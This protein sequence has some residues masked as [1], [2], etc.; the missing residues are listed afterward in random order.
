M[1]FH[2]IS[3]SM[4]L[5]SAFDEKYCDIYG[6]SWPKIT[7]LYIITGWKRNFPFHQNKSTSQQCFSLPL[8][9]SR[10]LS[11]STKSELHTT[12]S[13]SNH[14]ICIKNWTPAP[15]ATT[16]SV[17]RLSGVHKLIIAFQYIKNTILSGL[18]TE[19]FQ[20]RSRLFPLSPAI[21]WERMSWEMCEYGCC[22]YSQQHW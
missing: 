12:L 13:M 2:V 7:N 19:L 21:K 10:S 6:A 15:K 20:I 9:R 4:H 16:S 1:I 22:C 11:A 14:H 8:F 3:Q 18:Q 5:W 17:R